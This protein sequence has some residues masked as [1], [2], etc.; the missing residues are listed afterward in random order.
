M[1]LSAASQPQ[2][3]GTW[4]RVTTCAELATALTK[5]GLKKFVLE[6]VAGNGFISGVTRPNQIANP[7]NPCQGA[8]TRKHSHFFTKDRRFGS[9]DW[10]GQPVDD[11]TYRLVDSRTLVISKEFPKERSATGSAAKRSRSLR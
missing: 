10:R 4:Q 8:V 6:A 3:V 5:A 1:A 9:L 7:A 2:L 11:G